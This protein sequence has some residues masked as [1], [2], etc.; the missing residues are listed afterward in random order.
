MGSDNIDNREMGSDK[1]HNWQMGLDNIHNWERGE[2]LPF[3]IGMVITIVGHFYWDLGLKQNPYW[4]M[5]YGQKIT[6]ILGEYP[7]SPCP[8]TSSM[9]GCGEKVIKHTRLSKP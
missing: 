3:P 2:P 1:I 9:Y 4:D 6:G 7:S 5:G 8:S